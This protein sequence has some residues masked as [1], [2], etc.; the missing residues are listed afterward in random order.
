LQ[1]QEFLQLISWLTGTE[2]KEAPSDVVLLERI[3]SDD[4]RVVDCNEFNELLLL[5]NKNRVSEPFY[6]HF[7]GKNCS[8]AKFAGCV[9]KFQETAML[10]YG[11]FIF[12][13]RTLSPIKDEAAFRTELGPLCTDGTDVLSGRS[14]RLL[15]IEEIP[16]SDTSLVGYLSATQIVADLERCKLLLLACNQVGNDASDWD[17]LA[18]AIDDLTKPQGRRPVVGIIENFRKRNP[19][20]NVADFREFLQ[21]SSAAIGARHIRMEQVQA[22]AIRNQ[23]IYLTWDQMDVYFATSMR[24]S[25]EFTDLYDFV[26]ALMKSPELAALP[27]SYFDPTQSYTKERVDKGLVES[28]MLKRAR[29][30]VYSVQDTDTLGKDS[31]L[32]ATL[33]QGKPVIA[34]VPTI[35]VNERTAELV[36]SDPAALLD[37]L[38]FVLYADERFL[39]ELS[40]EDVA[41]VESFR[42][43]N[44]FTRSMEFRS[45]PGPVVVNQFR[46]KFQ[47]DLNRLAG[48][49]AGSEQRIYDSRANTLKSFHPLGLQVHLDTGVANGVLVVRTIADCA[50]LLMHILTNKMEFDVAE[51]KAN[52]TLRDKISGSMFRVVTKNKKVNNCFWNFYLR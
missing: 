1:T 28:L 4:H 27:I 31:E 18:T 20:S 29:C 42:A 47:A 21:R 35:S 12:A 25:W 11:D 19:D 17:G 7:F 38:R 26:K 39:S 49:V 32:A 45:V 3:L 36:E 50:K 9:K 37:R 48:I 13:F 14:K 43:L 23:D 15:E 6:H 22:I 46:E 52:W 41:F 51:E 30:T 10:R 34:Y 33:A 44:E 8:I 24:K 2:T 16:R 5:V 40:A